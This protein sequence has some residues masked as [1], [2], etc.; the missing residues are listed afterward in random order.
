MS[1]YGEERELPEST[2]K[3]LK[4]EVETRWPRAKW[5]NRIVRAC[6]WE[7]FKAGYALGMVQP[8]E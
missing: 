6:F 1:I 2:R 5:E 7:G 4:R 3:Y 8:D